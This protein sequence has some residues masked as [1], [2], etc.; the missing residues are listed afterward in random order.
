MNQKLNNDDDRLRLY[1]PDGLPVVRG[2]RTNHQPPFFNDGEPWYENLCSP[3]HDHPDIA[4]EMLAF[5][6]T[7]AEV[8]NESESSV[9]CAQGVYLPSGDVAIVLP[10]RTEERVYVAALFLTQQGL[11]RRA[12]SQ[13]A[14]GLGGRLATGSEN[15]SVAQALL[16]HAPHQ[17]DPEESSNS[18]LLNLYKT[19]SVLDDRGAIHVDG[20]KIIRDRNL[21][22]STRADS[23]GLIVFDYSKSVFY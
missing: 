4:N 2:L 11:S 6:R 8:Q 23:Y 14:Q 5:L 12:C 19:T 7:L 10:M 3:P 15:R 20:D 16:D 18:G 17:I 1:N 21:R 22:R 9:P 13:F